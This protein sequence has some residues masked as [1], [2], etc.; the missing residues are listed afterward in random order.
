MNNTAGLSDTGK[1]I[2]SGYI[3]P[4]RRIFVLQDVLDITTELI[5]LLEL[6]GD[7]PSILMTMKDEE[8]AN[9]RIIRES[10]ARITLKEHTYCVTLNLINSL[11]NEYPDYHV[12]IPGAV[13]T[14]LAHDIGKIPDVIDS[15][16]DTREHPVISARKLRDMFAG[17]NEIFTDKVIRAIE[18]HHSQSNNSFTRMLQHADRK[19]RETELLKLSQNSKIAP[20]SSWFSLEDF[21]KRLDPHINFAKGAFG[22]KAFSFR[23]VIYCRPDLI[24]KIVKDLCVEFYIIDLMFLDESALEKAI[25]RIVSH[26]RDHDMIPDQLKANRFTQKYILKTYA[27]HATRSY[28][29]ILT[30]LKPVGFYN[31]SEL[32]SRKIGFLETIKSVSRA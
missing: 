10:L 26:L 14:A 20:L 31:M 30:P 11:K 28:N 15:F 23:G 12:H 16:S 29:A 22:W 24:Y 3:Q 21:Y 9:L 5:K 8:S 4:Y 6:H 17:K 7:C 18:S 32:E 25:D 19:A 27:T 2:I 1:L 13:V